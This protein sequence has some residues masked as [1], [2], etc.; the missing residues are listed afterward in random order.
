MITDDPVCWP[1]A[2][3]EHQIGGGVEVP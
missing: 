3:P 1:R 2:L